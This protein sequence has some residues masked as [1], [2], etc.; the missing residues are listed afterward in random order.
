MDDGI[1]HHLLLLSTSSLTFSIFS[2][3]ALARLG[4][5]R[6]PCATPRPSLSPALTRL[7][8]GPEANFAALVYSF[9]VKR[10]I[11]GQGSGREDEMSTAQVGTFLGARGDL[12]GFVGGVTPVRLALVLDTLAVRVTV[13]QFKA[14]AAKIGR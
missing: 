12:P 2:F 9:E 5:S 7:G 6:T 13:E 14:G 3:G 1:Y 4:L 11:R 8:Q 10:L